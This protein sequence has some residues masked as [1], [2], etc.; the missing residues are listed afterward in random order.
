MHTLSRDD[1]GYAVALIG[2]GLLFD[3]VAIGMIADDDDEAVRH[4]FFN[5]PD[6]RCKAL[7][8]I[9]VMTKL[10]KE[11]LILSVFFGKRRTYGLLIK[12]LSIEIDI[13]RRMIRRI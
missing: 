6:K 3:V 4:L 2:I 7:V 8:R 10:A 13:I 11:F 12:A 9:P 5:L 1:K